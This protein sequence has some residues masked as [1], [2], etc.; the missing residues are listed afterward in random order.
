MCLK[1]PKGTGI[2][3]ASLCLTLKGERDRTRLVVPKPQGIPR[4]VHRVY[5]RGIP[6]GVH[7][8]YNSGIPWGVHRCTTVVYPGV[9]IGWCIPRWYI[10]GVHRVVYTGYMPPYLPRWCIPGYMPPY[11]TLPGTPCSIPAY[12]VHPGTPSPSDRGGREEALG[13]NLQIVRVTRRIEASLLPKG[14]RDGGPL[15][16]EFP[17]PSRD[18]VVKDWIDEGSYPLYYLRN[19]NVAQRGHFSSGH[20]IVEESGTSG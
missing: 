16:A 8:V 17:A 20:P 12:S 6:R 15:C 9:Y 19:S 13:S 5:N 7:R 1:S 11:Y 2:E 14:V 10:P 18:K 3:R 4:G